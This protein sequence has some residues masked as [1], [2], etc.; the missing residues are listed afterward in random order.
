MI[1]GLNFKKMIN[2]CSLKVGRANLGVS[3]LTLK[4]ISHTVRSGKNRD[5][6]FQPTYYYVRP[7][8][9]PK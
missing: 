3:V 1:I 2:F 4:H 8:I 7:H 6:Y 9:Y 5:K